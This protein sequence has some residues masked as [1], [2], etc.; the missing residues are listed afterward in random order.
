M[1]TS[2]NGINTTV[3]SQWLKPN[4]NNIPDNLKS[5]P[6]AVWIAEPRDGQL[7]KYNKAPRSPLTGFK[8]G[9]DKPE[10]FGS[11]EQAKEAYQTGNYTG[12]GVLLTGNGIVGF[13]VDDYAITFTNRPDVK[14]WVEQ[15]TKGS[16]DDAYAEISPSGN[17]LRLFVRGNLPDQG[18]KVGSL[19]VYDNKRFL[20]ITGASYK[21]NL[22]NL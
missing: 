2:P 8:I 20:T 4:F 11:F 16:S 17:G 1:M 18:R 22:V 5:Q 13:D 3:P 9:A 21:F 12:V 14:A 15:A 10:L 7:G 6:W 19:E